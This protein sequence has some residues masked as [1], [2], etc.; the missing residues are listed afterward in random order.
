[1]V[2]TL[3]GKH[4]KYYEAILQLRDVKQEVHDFVADELKKAKIPVTEVKTIKTG[5]DLYVADSDFTV[6]LGRKLQR[7]YGGKTLTT[8]SLYGAKGGKQ[9]Y[10]VT[11]LFRGVPFKK[12][13]IVTYCDEEY[14]IKGMAKDI[15][16]QNN[17]SGKKIHISYENMKHLKVIS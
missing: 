13:D 10:R 12:N 15:L 4:P 17:K 6:A 5:T 11:V 7:K 14:T 3:V 1:M 2:R 9:I 8:S 16:I